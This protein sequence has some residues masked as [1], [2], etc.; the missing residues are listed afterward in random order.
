M[1]QPETRAR[2]RAE[3]CL[4]RAALYARVSTD[5]HEREETVASQVDRLQEA[6]ETHGEAVLPGNVCIDDGIS[7]TRLDRPALER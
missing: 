3:S 5:K 2:S 4:G 1:S 6:A 7:G